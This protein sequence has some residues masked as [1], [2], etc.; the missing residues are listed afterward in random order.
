M[1]AHDAQQ[2]SLYALISSVAQP[3]AA[4]MSPQDLNWC[5]AYPCSTVSAS[6]TSGAA[7]LHPVWAPVWGVFENAVPSAK[8]VSESVIRSI[9]YLGDWRRC[10]TLL[11]ERG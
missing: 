4:A 1:R 5:A 7:S 9:R 11:G 8:N 10:D 2:V 6:T 3:P